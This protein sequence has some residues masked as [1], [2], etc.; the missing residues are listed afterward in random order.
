MKKILNEWKRFLMEGQKDD[1]E[2]AGILLQAIEGG[3]KKAP[4]MQNKLRMQKQRA[5]RV[6]K[7]VLGDPDLEGGVFDNDLIWKGDYI[8]HFLISTKGNSNI[9]YFTDHEEFVSRAQ[10]ALGKIE[11]ND[12]EIPTR[13]PLDFRQFGPSR[14]GDAEHSGGPGDAGLAL[15]S[16]AFGQIDRVD[17]DL[18]IQKWV[19]LHRAIWS[20]DKEAYYTAAQDAL[21]AVSFFISL[22]KRYA[23]HDSKYIEGLID[24]HM[25]MESMEPPPSKTINPKQALIDARDKMKEVQTQ[26][27]AKKKEKN[28]SS[29]DRKKHEELTKEV[30]VL[31]M[32]LQVAKAEYRE[33]LRGMRG[34]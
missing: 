22:Y 3:N 17:L 23:S 11:A 28:N 32:S 13:I 14:S 19:K 15:P 30:E 6:L 2:I 26:I 7:T 18:N 12:F 4:E 5:I 29:R 8:L 10:L 9:K 1:L 27:A 16:A 34:R 31:Q 20:G 33:V 25:R 21:P 24:L